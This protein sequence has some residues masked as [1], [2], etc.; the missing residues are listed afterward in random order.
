MSTPAMGK[1]PWT[2]ALAGPLADVTCLW[3]DLD[4][5]HV[6]PAPIS[7]PPTS[8]LWGWRGSAYLVRV[9][10]DGGTAFVAVHEEAAAPAGPGGLGSDNARTL[11]WSPVDGRVTGSRGRGPSAEGGGV[12]AAYDQ[13][14]IDGIG[15]GAGPVTFLRPARPPST[16]QPAG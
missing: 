2:Q 3:Q 15:D 8:L 11:P 10:L 6:E 9:R 14:V 13:I 7:P 12:G 5:L 1:M 16:G 4:G